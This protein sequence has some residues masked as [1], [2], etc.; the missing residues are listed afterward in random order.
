M[1]FEINTKI[2]LNTEA[3]VL[4]NKMMVLS[5]TIKQEFVVKQL[6][7]SMH[8]SLLNPAVENSFIS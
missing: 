6:V 2:Q 8:L 7:L 4:I 3:N 1:P 5:C